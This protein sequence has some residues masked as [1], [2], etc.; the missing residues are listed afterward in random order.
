MK[1][2]NETEDSLTVE[3]ESGELQQLAYDGTVTIP[4]ENGKLTIQ[5]GD[6]DS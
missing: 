2:V 4:L 6:N 3:L 1:V 5:R